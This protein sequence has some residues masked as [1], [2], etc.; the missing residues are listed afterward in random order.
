M[1]IQ[2]AK[3]M[4]GDTKVF[5]DFE[6]DPNF[7]QMCKRLLACVDCTPENRI[8]TAIREQMVDSADE[9]AAAEASGHITEYH[10]G[11]VQIWS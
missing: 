5:A 10:S 6:R 2:E 3:E 7:A 9:Y 11:L 8:D 4:F 1:K